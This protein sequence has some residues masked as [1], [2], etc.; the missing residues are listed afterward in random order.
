MEV[1]LK[2][3]SEKRSKIVFM[4]DVRGSEDGAQED[5]AE[6]GEGAVGVGVCGDRDCAGGVVEIIV[7]WLSEADAAGVAVDAVLRKNDIDELN[8][9]KLLGNVV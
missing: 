3:C 7:G 5:E 9:A 6:P 2:T 4:E 8:E 1:P